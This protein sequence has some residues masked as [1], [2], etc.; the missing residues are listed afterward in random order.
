MVLE[1]GCLNMSRVLQKGLP[2]ELEVE[3]LN[4]CFTLLLFVEFSAFTHCVACSF[5]SFFPSFLILSPW[6]WVI[7]TMTLLV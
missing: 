6:N 7:V 5:L 4:C 2:E 3:N 1:S